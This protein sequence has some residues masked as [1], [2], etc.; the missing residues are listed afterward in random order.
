MGLEGEL[1]ASSPEIGPEWRFNRSGKREKA[2]S[3]LENCPEFFAT[4]RCDPAKNAGAAGAWEPGWASRL[5][6]GG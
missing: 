5:A 3:L 2:W 1:F 6:R 4:E